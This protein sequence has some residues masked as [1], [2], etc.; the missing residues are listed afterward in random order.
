MSLFVRTFAQIFKCEVTMC[1]N[2]ILYMPS[3]EQPFPEKSKRVE[4]VTF[5]QLYFV[6]ECLRLLANRLDMPISQ[7]S[8]ALEQKGLMPKLFNMVRKQPELSKVQ[9]ANRMTKMFKEFTH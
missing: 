3:P 4:R 8:R 5:R 6:T 1:S 7:A 9:V 2:E